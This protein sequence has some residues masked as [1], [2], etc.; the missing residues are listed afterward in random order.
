MHQDAQP[1]RQ[2]KSETKD[3]KSKE[4]RWRNQREAQ[5]EADNYI[6]RE[7]KDRQH[8]RYT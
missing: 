6:E 8:N 4:K 7:K 5:S 1:I 2:L 3:K